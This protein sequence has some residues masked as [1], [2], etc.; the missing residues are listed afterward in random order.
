[1]KRENIISLIGK[2]VKYYRTLHK[3]SLSALA[4]EAN[5]SKSTLF[6][7]ELGETNPTISTLEAIANALQIDISEL[8]NSRQESSLSLIENPTHNSS[9]LYQLRLAPFESYHYTTSDTHSLTIEVINGS[10]TILN[11]NIHLCAHQKVP[12]PSNTE[13]IAN[14]KGATA[15]IRVIDKNTPLLLK[16]DIIHQ[17]STP[18]EYRHL[19][20]RFLSQPITR[21]ILNKESSLQIDEKHPYINTLKKEYN[22]LDT[23]YFFTRYIGFKESIQENMALIENTHIQNSLLD[24]L[25]RVI[26]K[27][28]LEESYCQKIT[29]EPIAN[30]IQALKT[31]LQKRYYALQIINIEELLNTP[32]P[33]GYYLLIDEFLKEENSLDATT[34][35]INL[36]R[37]LESMYPLQKEQLSQETK[38]VYQ[39]ITS[40]LPEIF[41]YAYNNYSE[42]AYTMSQKLYNS[43]NLELSCKD[44]SKNCF[45]LFYCELFK[46]LKDAI[47][48]YERKSVY[49]PKMRFES[50]LKDQGAITHLSKLLFPS[51]E[52]NGKYLYLIE[53][54]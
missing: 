45:E 22:S 48:M 41:Y 38:R 27:P 24:F 25:D 36:Y 53:F 43:I 23:Y 19:L 1:M 4:K 51:L 7:L 6:S 44:S 2:K 52:E 49:M 3:I 17:S 46:K 12:L 21:V 28:Y 14:A 11:E 30:Y 8:I 37:T 10:L 42:L 35:T 31:S 20:Q 39:K 9:A 33:K 50:I 18:L 40:T 15:L 29:K 5:I 47:D 54:P 32:K 34:L 26:S 16:D 13:L